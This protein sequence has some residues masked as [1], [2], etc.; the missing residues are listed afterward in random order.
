MQHD[1]E[2]NHARTDSSNAHQDLYVRDAC[3]TYRPINDDELLRHAKTRAEWRALRIKGPLQ[4]KD[5]TELLITRLGAL[6]HEVF[7]VLFLDTKHRLIAV[8]DLFR[9]TVDGAAVYPREVI[10]A[11][12][13]HNAQALIV[14]HNHP[15]GDPTPSAADRCITTKL[16]SALRLLDIR[17]LDH[18]IVAGTKTYRFDDHGLM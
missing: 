17:L 6:E 13:K 8:E 9:G 12:L 14:A 1:I 2:F 11:A 18:I 15:S 4:P 5:A 3:G 10:K 7:T 16:Q